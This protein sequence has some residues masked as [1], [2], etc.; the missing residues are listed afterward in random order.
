MGLSRCMKA[1]LRELLLLSITGITLLGCATT[2][3][4]GTIEGTSYGLI[5]TDRFWLM[6]EHY[7]PGYLVLEFDGQDLVKMFNFFTYEEALQVPPGEHTVGYVCPNRSQGLRH[8]KIPVSEGKAYLLITDEG[9]NLVDL[10]PF[11]RDCPTGATADDPRCSTSYQRVYRDQCALTVAEISI[12]AIDRLR[13]QPHDFFAVGAKKLLRGNPAESL[14][15]DNAARS[16]RYVVGEM[17]W[18]PLINLAYSGRINHRDRARILASY[19]R[20]E[21]G[22]VFDVYDLNRADRCEIY[23]DPYGKRLQQPAFE[24]QIRSASDPIVRDYQTRLPAIAKRE[25]YDQFATVYQQVL[26]YAYGTGEPPMC[27]C[28]PVPDRIVAVAC[29]LLKPIMIRTGEGLRAVTPEDTAHWPTY[30]EPRH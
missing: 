28:E 7:D 25:P 10:K 19:N 2:P 24:R 22:K 6:D 1:H 30:P 18:L 15:V 13:E 8:V 16:K 17:D 21:D 12:D 11:A 4:F 29:S 9:K 26:G 14:S 23:H 27:V 20:A 3:K 5:L